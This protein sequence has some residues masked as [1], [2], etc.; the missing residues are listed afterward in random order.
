[1]KHHNHQGT[2]ILHEQFHQNG[3]H[4]EYFDLLNI[5]NFADKKYLTINRVYYIDGI[6]STYESRYVYSVF[7]DGA[8]I[9]KLHELTK[10]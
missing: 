7:L 6:Y 5:Q 3:K 1:M 9:E 4:I 10:P 8:T 2:V